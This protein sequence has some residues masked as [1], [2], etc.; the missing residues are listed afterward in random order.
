M[1]TSDGDNLSLL[2]KSDV[3]HKRTLISQ[4]IILFFKACKGGGE[5]VKNE[6]GAKMA[7]VFTIAEIQYLVVGIL[8]DLVWPP[9]VFI[10]GILSFFAKLFDLNSP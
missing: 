8:D 6:N 4:T 2:T 9:F 5:T 3:T 1:W 7:V 10:L